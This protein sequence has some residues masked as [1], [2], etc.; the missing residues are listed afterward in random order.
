MGSHW[1]SHAIEALA[2]GE[3]CKVTPH[4]NSMRPRIVSGATVTLSP[5]AAG[6]EPQEGDA[7]LVRCKGTVFLH[8]VSAVRGGPEARQFQISNNRGHVNGW[9]SR[10]AVY[11]K[12]TLIEN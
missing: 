2:R 9:V 8:L 10:E 11:G 1:A 6:E 7:V 5:Y 3:T 12:A 4:G